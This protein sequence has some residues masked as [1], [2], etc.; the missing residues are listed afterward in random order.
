MYNELEIISENGGIMVS[1][2]VSEALNNISSLLAVYDKRTD[3]FTYHDNLLAYFSFPFDGEPIWTLLFKNGI[4]SK[5]DAEEIKEIVL[6]LNEKNS[7]FFNVYSFG[8]KGRHILSFTYLDEKV[9][10]LF[11]LFDQGDLDT[12]TIKYDELTRL[13]S[14]N[15]FCSETAKLNKNNPDTQYALFYFDL[16]KFKAINDFFGFSAGDAFL[17]YISEIL[18][19]GRLPIALACRVTSDHFAFLA[20][21]TNCSAKSIA[22][23]LISEIKAYDIPFELSINIGIY[24]VPKNEETGNSMLDKAMLAQA[25]IKGNYTKQISFY[26]EQLRAATLS[27]QEIFADMAGALADEQFLVYYQPQYNHSTGMLVGAEALV[28]WL[29]PK[30]GMISPARFIPIFEKN[31]FITKLDLYVFE[32]V[33]AFIKNSI[34]NNYSVVPVS[35]NFSKHDIFSQGFVKTLEKIRKK[36]NVPAK[37]LRIEITESVLIGNNTAVNDILNSLHAYGYTIEMDDFGSGYSSLNVLK[38]LDFDIIKLDMLFL[39]DSGKQGRGGTIL[40][41]V[42]NMAKWLN[43]PVIAEGVETVEQADFLKSIGCNYIQGYLYSKPLPE[44][45]YRSLIN[46]SHIGALIPQMNI[47]EK[48]NAA[49]FWNPESQETLIFSNFV[50]AAAIFS[51]DVTTGAVEIL[52]VNKKYLREL[53]MNLSEHDIIHKNPMD[54]LNEL[55]RNV[56][57]A[58]LKKAIDTGEEQEFETWRE[59]RSDCCGTENF[60]IRSNVSVIGKSNHQVLFYGMIRNITSEKNSINSMIET[61]KR[62]KMASEQVNIYFWE[63]TIATHEMRPCFRCM[64]DLGLPPLLRNY[65]DSAIERGIFPPEVADMY[66]DWHIQVA[67]GVK[68]LEAIIPL[69]P[70][71]IPFRVRY[72]TE[73]D[74]FGNP[75]KAYGSAA[76]VVD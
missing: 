35:V 11:K 1:G 8:V 65:P 5:N 34:D 51:Y 52:R 22:E 24:D 76:L 17:V 42:V 26:D 39:Q 9:I 15:H 4:I 12:E 63:Y 25:A 48:L 36:Y 45:E 40:S 67:N 55:N 18:K 60:C 70:D 75:I 13:I 56:Y 46:R 53:G 58:A 47:D 62:F 6:S 10:I 2:N 32:K 57:T 28:R 23:A 74:E 73:F 68:E 31:G 30:K 7:V 20:D 37:Y 66:R 38:D 19:S 71:R 50:G 72:T 3:S 41:S 61:E 64:R 54:S 14:R 29:H 27:E 44:E 69:T 59:I 43:L 33:A 16:I 21:T 49:N